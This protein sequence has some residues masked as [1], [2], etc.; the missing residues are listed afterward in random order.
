KGNR[1]PRAPV[2]RGRGERVESENL[3]QECTALPPHCD[4]AALWIK[5]RF[6][7]VSSRRLFKP[8]QRGFDATTSFRPPK[9]CDTSP[10]CR[11]PATVGGPSKGPRWERRRA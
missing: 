4:R 8:S 9:C 2:H 5:C 11:E 10:G 6:G 7:A 3:P 1:P